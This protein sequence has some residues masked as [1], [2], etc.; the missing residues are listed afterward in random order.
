[1]GASLAAAATVIV[2]LDLIA[3]GTSFCTDGSGLV[4]ELE[5]E[6]ELDD[7]AELL[8]LLDAPALPGPPELDD[9]LLPHAA[10]ATAHTTASQIARL[11]LKLSMCTALL[12]VTFPPSQ[13][14]GAVNDRYDG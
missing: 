6:L 7:D 3:A 8:E 10:T 2:P 9:L 1:L 5:L 14:M 13:D 11:V 12:Y 4:A